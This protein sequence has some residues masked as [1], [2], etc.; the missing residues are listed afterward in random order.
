MRT[1]L[2]S[3]LSLVFLSGCATDKAVEEIEQE[4]VIPEEVRSVVD[5]ARQ[6]AEGGDLLAAREK[7]A[8]L[9]SENPNDLGYRIEYASVL[10][11]SGGIE[12][13]EQAYIDASDIG[14]CQL[15]VDGNSSSGS[16]QK[17]SVD[18]VKRLRYCSIALNTLG[19]IAD[20]DGDYPAAEGFYQASLKAFD[21]DVSIYNNYG[22]SLMM[23]HRYPE[24]EAIF[25]HGVKLDPYAERLRH[26]L[27]LAKAWQGDYKAALKAYSSGRDD[28]EAYNNIGYIALLKQDYQ[29]AVEY[30]ERAITLS[31]SY[32]AKAGQNLEKAQALIQSAAEAEKAAA[33]TKPVGAES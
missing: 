21:R 8:L 4:F 16:E 7:Y 30:F 20:M 23:A 15:G 25:Q 12:E 26:N 17:Q 31:P 18:D 6:A 28:P 10:F 19:V 24:A 27:A 5:E 2:L 29:L 1:C 13:A 11:R 22:Y 3:F 14:R 9:V 33:V 32:Y